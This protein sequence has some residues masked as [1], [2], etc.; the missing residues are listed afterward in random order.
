M[1]GENSTV[2]THMGKRV[3]PV[4][5]TWSIKR[6]NS[7]AFN[8]ESSC[9]TVRCAST[10]RMDGNN[11]YFIHA[12]N[13]EIVKDVIKPPTLANAACVVIE[14]TDGESILT[15]TRRDT[16]IL[17]LPGGKQDPGESILDA[18]VR[19]VREE[20]GLP[21]SPTLCIPIYSDIIEGSDGCNFYCTTYLYAA[22]FDHTHF[23]TAWQIE[24][25][26]TVAFRKWFDLLT[27]GTFAKYNAHVE[28]NVSIA[29][30]SIPVL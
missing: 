15:V 19:E 7:C 29:R 16:D 1:T 8:G 28:L 5:S 12:P 11:V 17:A 18:A 3:I 27:K 22:R 4:I 30:K 20:T 6:C 10:E 14:S 21:I 9:D 26:I 2:E 25:G 13:D 24:K 23:D